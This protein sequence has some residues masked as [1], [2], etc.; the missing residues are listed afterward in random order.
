MQK[1]K[2]TPSERS[3]RE[4]TAISCAIVAKQRTKIDRNKILEDWI[5]FKTGIMDDLKKEME[6]HVKWIPDNEQ[7]QIMETLL[8][9]S[10]MDEEKID[11]ALKDLVDGKWTREQFYKNLDDAKD[12]QK[13]DDRIA[14]KLGS[15][16]T[17]AGAK[18]H[19]EFQD[20]MDRDTKN[21][22][23]YGQPV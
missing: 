2:L 12:N 14:S 16:S 23:D 4:A 6:V 11:G 22:E 3:C 1:D 15:A 21:D 9:S 20:K 8:R 13:P 7:A 10:T 19:K 5:F 18:A 17:P